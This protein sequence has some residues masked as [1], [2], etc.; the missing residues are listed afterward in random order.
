M[1]RIAPLVAL[2][3]LSACAA[4]EADL[5]AATE[6]PPAAELTAP[7]PT[8][9][10]EALATQV[11]EATV[12]YQD[13]AVAE[14]EGYMPDPTGT[15]VDAAMVGAPAE[16]GAMGIHYFRPDLLGIA[17]PTPPVAGSDVVI[18]PAQPEILVYEPQA[19]G[20]LQLVAAEYLVFEES[21]S[22]AGNAEL[23]NLAGEP[24]VRMAD[25]PAT[26]ADEA[27]GFTPHH[28]LHVWVHRDN[29]AGLFA[30]FNPSVTCANAMASHEGM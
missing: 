24:F 25:D 12:K 26:P 18:D 19:D 4:E 6:A 16:I 5:E 7:V 3:A 23:P 10:Q 15:C 8:P 21:W 11:R 29:P 30:E 9:E 17:D 27:H 2:L 1:R 14:A 13:V 22:A 28:E 20:S